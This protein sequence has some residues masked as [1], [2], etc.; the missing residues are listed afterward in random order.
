MVRFAPFVIAAVVGTVLAA[1][2]VHAP[3][4]LLHEPATLDLVRRPEGRGL[5]VTREDTGHHGQGPTRP[6]DGRHEQAVQQRA[7]VRAAAAMVTP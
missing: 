7:P 3:D 5:V 2:P 1:A 4:D 6:V